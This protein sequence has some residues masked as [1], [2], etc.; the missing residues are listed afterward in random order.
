MLP[1][2]TKILLLTLSLACGD[3]DLAPDAGP[4]PDA[5]NGDTAA[6]VDAGREDVP[7]DV[8]ADIPPD[9]PPDTFDA[10]PPCEGPPGLYRIPQCTELAEGVRAYSPHYWLWSDGADKERYISLP[11]GEVIDTTDPDNW[12]YPVGTRVWK[13]FLVG[14]VRIETRLL[15]KYAEGSG[16]DSWTTQTFAWN[17]AQDFVEEV[18]GGR[19][20]ALGTDHDIPDRNACIRCH[21]QTGRLDFL[22]SFTAIQLNHDD[23]GFSLA[24]LNDEGWLSENIDIAAAVI[25]GTQEESDALGYLHA[26]CGNCHGNALAPSG[27][28]MWVNVGIDTVDDTAT[29]MTGVGVPSLRIDGEAT[30][31][32]V[33]GDSAL[34]VAFRRMQSRM[35]NLQMPPIGTEAVDD[36]GSLTV[37]TWID[38]LEE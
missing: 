16:F 21:G 20:N 2:C 28:S 1:R 10:G 30:I 22:T 27:L 26:N 17:E 15:E 6:L 19:E 18:M 14:G 35:M 24:E 25:P 23:A 31:R 29:Y 4:N 36:V 34:S 33:P 7:M 5:S 3:D 11:A 13:T 8:P 37:Q 9:I 32:I 38:G 12:I